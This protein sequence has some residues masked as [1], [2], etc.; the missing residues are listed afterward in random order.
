MLLKMTE[1]YLILCLILPKFALKDRGGFRHAKPP[2]SVI[3]QCAPLKVDLL[4]ASYRMHRHQ[5]HK[6]VPCEPQY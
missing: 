4:L 1:C 5:S 3:L 2:P 6:P